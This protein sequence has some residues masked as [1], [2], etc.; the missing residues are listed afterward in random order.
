M[1]ASVNISLRNDIT[2]ESTGLLLE[3]VHDRAPDWDQR[4]E[5]ERLD[6]YLEWEG[7]VGRLHAVIESDAKG[8][9]TSEQQRHLRKLAREI[10]C[11]RE[12]ILRLG[13]V[14]P[15]LGHLLAEL[16]LSPDERVAHDINALLHW[17]GRLRMMGDFWD[18]PLLDARE[19]QTFPAEWDNVVGQFANVEAVA[20]RG[21]LKPES[22]EELR[23]VAEYLA[24]LLPTMR[25]LGVR[26]PDLEALERARSVE[27]A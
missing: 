5:G 13:L 26:L 2:L 10:V 20:R 16:T 19:K 12:I 24:E 6:I 15:D 22:R 25:R 1:A 23:R 8:T 14:Y 17:A 7:L 9:L 4:P 27:A 3:D 21:G 18:S 11:S